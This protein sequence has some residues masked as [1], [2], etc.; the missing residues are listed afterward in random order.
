M[1]KH[2]TQT[3]ASQTKKIR[4]RSNGSGRSGGGRRR[5]GRA[6][7]GRRLWDEEVFGYGSKRCHPWGPQVLIYFSFYQSFFGV[8]FFDPLPFVVCC[9]LFAVF[10]FAFYDVFCFLCIFE[11]LLFCF[12]CFFLVFYDVFMMFLCF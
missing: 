1:Q 7:S 9:L 3:P 6:P 4:C 8:P 10:L 11:I 5:G 12:C 2:P